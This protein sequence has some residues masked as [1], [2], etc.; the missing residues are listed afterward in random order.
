[1]EQKRSKGQ[2]GSGENGTNSEKRQGAVRAYVQNHGTSLRPP[3]QHRFM[4]SSVRIESPGVAYHVMCRR[5]RQEAIILEHADR[6]LFLQGTL[7]E[8]R[9]SVRAYVQKHGKADK[10]ESRQRDR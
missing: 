1:M 10:G 2:N 3:S 8:A 6:D 9:G 5:D 4:P 7:G